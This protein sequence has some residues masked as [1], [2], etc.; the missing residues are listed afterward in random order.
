MSEQFGAAFC[1]ARITLVCAAIFGVL[2]NGIIRA[3][4]CPPDLEGAWTGTLPATALLHLDIELREQA[5]GGSEA[6]LRSVAGSEIVPVLTDGTWWWFQSIAH[7][8]V[9]AGTPSADSGTVGGFLYHGSALIRLQ[10]LAAPGARVRTWAGSWSAL[11]VA[12][13]APR[14]DLYVGNDGE[15]GLGGYFFFRD[16]RLPGLWG[17]GVACRGDTVTMYERVLG[18]QFTGQLARGADR[19]TLT[20]TGPAGSAPITFRRMSDT[21]V[22]DRPD[23]PAVSAREPEY[24]AYRGDAPDPSDDGWPTAAPADV[25]LDSAIVAAM[26]RAIAQGEF[27]R[28]HAVVVARRG[29]LVVDEYFH[30]FDRDTWHDMRSASKTVTS[31]L[32]GLAIRDGHI[33][34]ASA[35]VL[36]FFPRYHRYAV[37][38]PRKMAMTLRHLLTMSS[39][40]DANDSDPQSVASENAYQSQRAQ[41]DWVKLALDAPMIAEPGTRVIYGG[42][43]PLILGGVL[44]NAVDEPVEWFAHRTLFGPLGIERYRF[45]VDPTGVPYMGGGLHLRPRDM[46]KYGQLY[47]NAGVWQGTR[48]LPEAWIGESWARYGRLEPLDRNGHEYGYLWWHHQY[49][50]DGRTIET[51]EA[52]GNGGQY[53]FVVPTLDLVAVITAGNY[54]G[55]LSMTRQPEEIMRNYVLPSVFAAEVR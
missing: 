50:V 46:L 34:D 36:T 21:E 8:I 30:G 33:A 40:L 51:I 55:G 47:L 28:T 53:V 35:R 10:L 41:P 39:G 32:V 4:V 43:N 6:R 52:R 49:E 25:G 7:P 14:F 9:F 24:G 27:P 11:G 3:Q 31:T 48:I 22:P 2:G 5:D 29:R 17:E 12:A 20:A 16:D 45:L 15:G 42:A 38:D 19:L 18:L 37:W 1:H 54:R 23:E 26:V 13:D 44:A